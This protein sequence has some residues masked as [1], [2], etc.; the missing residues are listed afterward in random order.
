MNNE[1]E[2][3]MRFV[4]FFINIDLN[5]INQLQQLW[6]QFWGFQPYR[7]W[8]PQNWFWWINPERCVIY[9]ILCDF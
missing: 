4:Y 6:N 2:L 9:F 5:N 8:N 3:M 7:S 1:N